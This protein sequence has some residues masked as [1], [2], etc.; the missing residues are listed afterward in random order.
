MGSD[1]GI[2]AILSDRAVI[3]VI[4]VAFVLMLAGGIVLPI[5]PLFARSFGVGYTE[6][7]ILVSAYGGARLAVDLAAGAAVDRWGER[8]CAAAGLVAGAAASLLTAL[9]PVFAL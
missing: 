3:S 8:V 2:R 6:T 5:L 4:G 7:G 1:H 9:A